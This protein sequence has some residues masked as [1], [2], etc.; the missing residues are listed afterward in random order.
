M[1]IGTE[2]RG[3]QTVEVLTLG[4]LGPVLAARRLAD[5]RPVVVHLVGRLE[6]PSRGRFFE[7][8]HDLA[9]LPAHPHVWPLLEAGL[10]DDGTCYLVSPR[11]DGSLAD[12]L[13]DSGPLPAPA[14]L[15]VALD[16][17]AGLD[18]L[19][20]A[21]L[22]HGNITPAN[23]LV[24]PTS[25]HS[26]RHDKP[27][28]PPEG[29]RR[30]TGP[31]ALAVPVLP[32]LSDGGP[33]PAA[34]YRPPEVFGG[35]DWTAASD[36]YALAATLFT[37]LS[38]KVPYAASGPGSPAGL[39]GRHAAPAVTA[40]TGD[41]PEMPLRVL[42]D[43]VPEL[44]RH[45][46]PD[47]VRD[48][49][50][51]GMAKDPAQRPPAP[52]AFAE[53]LAEA[54]RGG[55]SDRTRTG[56]RHGAEQLETRPPTAPLPVAPTSPSPSPAGRPLG[57]NY[58]LDSQIGRG[59]TGQV[60]RARRR[61]NGTP[62]AVKMLRSDLADEPETVTRFLRERTT[63]TLVRHPNLVRVHDLV[64]EGG[65]LAI[66]MDLVDGAD[67]RQV[68]GAAPIGRSGAARLLAQV[69][70]ALAAV[71]AAG[72][73]HRDLKP[74]NVLVEQP[75][76]EM[77]ARLT[78]FGIARAAADPSLTRSSR[79]LGTPAYLAPELAAGRPATASSDVYSF[80][81]MA[82]ELLAG[83][84]P[85]D[86]D[87]AAALIRAHMEDRPLRPAGLAEPLWAVLERCLAKAPDA[88]PTA[89][90][91]AHDLPGLAA[92]P[93]AAV[94]PATGAGPATRSDHASP[95]RPGARKASDGLE[96]LRTS[97]TSG[98]SS[99]AS[100]TSPSSPSSPSSSSSPS[101][102]SSPGPLHTAA[103]SVPPPRRPSPPPERRRPWRLLVA[104]VL[105][106]ILGASAGV[107]LAIHNRGAA[108]PPPAAAPAGRVVP[109]TFVVASPKPGVFE[110]SFAG[111]TELPGFDHYVVLLD[112]HQYFDVRPGQ[113]SYR[114]ALGT[115]ERHCFL[116]S[117]LVTT[118]QEIPQRRAEERCLAAG[119]R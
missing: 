26:G 58:I 9:T 90:E 46:V 111:G 63:L 14:A 25:A 108:P 1:R 16:A 19:H 45:D 78:D 75:A 30:S 87:N 7:Q 71:H 10:T 82:Y 5:D 39:R 98:T 85:F 22:L 24:V 104:A 40:M 54:Y 4:R 32:A 79:I 34:G 49:L 68:M 112:G 91:L 13:R 52:G 109:V 81:I 110:L 83:R 2:P 94:R 66:V 114:L 97:G 93:P 23:L 44:T 103:A 35:A 69:A 113:E 117:A 57:S 96:R 37:V 116:V 33:G 48:V 76:G 31:V 17:A 60:W 36:V 67:L 15:Q 21:G 11:A 47:A 50:R 42:A 100:G 27:D 43:P 64:A 77:V 8:A 29:D 20:A 12:R 95:W 65:T 101:S 102:P 3:Y 88:R 92:A 72:I 115:Q 51:Q 89:T 119:G 80:G 99:G 55:T 106:T 38:G 56:S 105:V 84:R 61:D 107:W 28:I 59:A 86:G 118:D 62:V 70:S 74:E 18:A 73:V 41:D 53:L 6:Q